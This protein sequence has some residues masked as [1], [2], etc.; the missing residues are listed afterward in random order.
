MPTGIIKLASNPS[1]C[2]GAKDQKDG[3]PLELL[4]VTEKNLPRI[5]WKWNSL[6]SQIVL[7]STEGDLNPLVITTSNCNN[8]NIITVNNRDISNDKQQWRW[9]GHTTVL[10]SLG[11]PGKVIDN[12]WRDVR[13]DNPIWL[14]YYN[15][16]PA[17]Q[18]IMDP[19]GVDELEDAK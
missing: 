16:S 5:L 6:N 7:V 17:Q 19:I 3:E 18:W 1:F 14:F 13:K 9:M 11:C 4:E 10:M 2:L 12:K 15:G 8:E